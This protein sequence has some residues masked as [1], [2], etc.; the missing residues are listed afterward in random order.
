MSPVIDGKWT[1]PLSAGPLKWDATKVKSMART[2]RRDILISIANVQSGHP[3]GPLGC[4]DYLAALWFHHL[5]IAPENPKLSERD[6]FVLSNGHCS[7]IMYSLL[8]RR[9]F[10]NPSYLL[11]FR[12]TISRLQ[13]HPNALKLPG[14]EVNTGSLGQG[15]SVAHGIAL[16]LRYRE[17]D[18][19]T[20]YCNCGDGELQEGNIWEAMMA[21]AH[22]ESDN[23]VCFIDY[24][25]AQIDGPM[26]KVMSIDP[27]DKKLD[28]FGW[29][30]IKADG[31]DHAACIQA[32]SEANDRSGK[33]TAI[34]FQT[35]MMKGL[36]SWENFE[37][38]SNNWKWHGRPPKLNEIGKMLRELY[39]DGEPDSEE[40]RLSDF[41]DPF[42][43]D[44]LNGEEKK[45]PEFSI[46]RRWY[47]RN[48][49]ESW[50][51]FGDTMDEQTKAIYDKYYRF[52][53]GEDAAKKFRLAWAK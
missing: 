42:I 36:P 10:F 3:G 4:A 38:Q 2:I 46:A 32:I 34:V 21:A 29:R 40:H 24:N 35:V 30:V 25:D 7:A 33:P 6:R 52:T 50:N 17:I 12:T 20:V 31:H 53:A 48:Y 13:G 28:A 14:L 23:L 22:Y 43:I 41:D 18:D 39:A 26:R 49:L 16:G 47:A 8:A 11:T 19:A 1:S 5:N 27:L 51:S 15:L 37:G 45:Y 9:G 44:A